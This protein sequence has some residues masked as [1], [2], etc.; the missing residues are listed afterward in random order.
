MI[1]FQDE[2]VEHET[3]NCFRVF[4]GKSKQKGERPIPRTSPNDR[5]AIV[6]AVAG[7]RFSQP[8]TETKFGGAIWAGEDSPYNEGFR[9]PGR[10]EDTYCL[11][12]LTAIAQ[13]ASTIPASK[14][15]IFR[16]P[17]E[18]IIRELTKNRKCRED[19]D[20]LGEEAG[21][22]KSAIA[23]IRAREGWTAFLLSPL[24]AKHEGTSKA[25]DLA[26][27]AISHEVVRP[28]PEIPDGF[29]LRGAK[30]STATQS[31]L[32]RRLVK[33]RKPSQR[34]RTAINLDIIR[35]AAKDL[36]GTPPTD[37]HIWK[38]TRDPVLLRNE[39]AFLFKTIHDAHRV[40][41]YWEKITNYENRAVCGVCDCMETME[42]I[43]T[44][45]EGS[46]CKIIWKL[47]EKL[48]KEKTNRR[49]PGT[50][51]GT[52]LAGEM[53][54]LKGDRDGSASR[55]LKIIIATS[56]HL[57]WVIRCE[58]RIQRGEHPEKR[59][60]ANEIHNR[61]VAKVNHRLHLDQAMA[62]KR[63]YESKAVSR[64]TVLATWSGTLLEEESL[65]E[66]WIR[67]DAVLVSIQPI[68]DRGG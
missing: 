63:R 43:L 56:S 15:I 28:W 16:V 32:Y 62:N 1:P 14:P 37:G 6:I 22:M 55:F 35:W 52:I 19:Q 33:T 40:G 51:F 25:R 29:E 45:C 60:T 30:L 58:R 13:A 21:A 39:R 3:A 4:T 61:W 47:A 20:W 53:A 2:Y 65:P 10:E 49:W 64:K 36:N 9:V 31:E 54:S 23:N 18:S 5:S 7:T 66:N 57:I 17:N 59:H 11:G 8:D 34:R 44:E 27:D 68:R 48:W 50:S 46:G 24:K 26:R 38:A 12:I 41:E 67:K 42:H